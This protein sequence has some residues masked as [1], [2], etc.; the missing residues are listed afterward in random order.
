MVR[1]GDGGRGRYGGYRVPHGSPPGR[2]PSQDPTS[3]TG[4]LGRILSA[5]SGRARGRRQCSGSDRT[6]AGRDGGSE[7]RQGRPGGQGYLV[8][9]ADASSTA[10]WG[11]DR[12][13]LQEGGQGR[14]TWTY[15][16]QGH[17]PEYGRGSQGYDGAPV[18][19]KPLPKGPSSPSPPTAPAT[20]A[21]KKTVVKCPPKVPDPP[22]VPEVPTS[23]EDAIALMMAPASS[24]SSLSG[25][26]PTTEPKVKAMPDQV[27]DTVPKQVAQ[28]TAVDPVAD[29]VPQQ[30]A[31]AAAA[32]SRRAHSS[33]VTQGPLRRWTRTSPDLRDQGTLRSS[34]R[35]FATATGRSTTSVVAGSRT[36]RRTTTT[37]LRSARSGA[38]AAGFAVVEDATVRGIAGHMKNI[39]AQHATPCIRSSTLT[40]RRQRRSRPGVSFRRGFLFAFFLLAGGCGLFRVA[41]GALSLAGGGF[42]FGY[43]D[44][45]GLRSPSKRLYSLLLCFGDSPHS[46]KE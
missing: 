10:T 43:L 18:P 17:R 2:G 39:C 22:T 25:P 46:E 41:F 14:S 16:R 9:F 40:S 8:W 13:G 20:P 15:V 7:F 34:R 24:S 30:S 32:S 26:P 3:C 5:S 44:G 11:Y 12:S 28:P 31:Q 33:Q 27:A 45:R 37:F 29:A 6:P 35:R 36:P 23:A 38:Q 1:L 21:K 4:R 42:L 19:V